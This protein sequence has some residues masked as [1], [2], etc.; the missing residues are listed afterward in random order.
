MKKTNK[1]FSMVE[2]IIVIAIMAILAGALAPALI[3][4]IN[5]SR[6][7]T[8]IQTAN[9][10]ATAVQTALANETGYDCCPDTINWST[11]DTF[12]DQT[13]S[14]SKT[15]K[16]T[17]G[18]NNA[19]AVKSKKCIAESGAQATGTGKSPFYIYVDKAQNVVKVSL[20]AS[21]AHIAYPAAVECLTNEAAQ[22]CSG[23]ANSSSSS[24]SN[25]NGN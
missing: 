3:K 5:K 16:S 14:F 18:G 13:D 12:W 17:I 19:P 21:G 25:A 9:T 8:D 20:G 2:L 24:S 15:L 6:V 4:Y 22:S 7:S 11:V 1:G 10:I 23:S